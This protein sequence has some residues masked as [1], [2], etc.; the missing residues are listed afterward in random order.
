MKSSLI[1]I[2]L[3]I[4]IFLEK[5]AARKPETIPQYHYRALGIFKKYETAILL[6]AKVLHV[7]FANKRAE[8]EIRTA[9]VKQK[10]SACFR[11]KQ[12]PS[13]LSDLKLFANNGEPGI[14]Y[15]CCHSNGIGRQNP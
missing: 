11:R 15:S 10:V 2:E 6:F 14:Q 4:A 13:L 12:Y 1:V 5:R 3:I 8:R 9:K 7:P